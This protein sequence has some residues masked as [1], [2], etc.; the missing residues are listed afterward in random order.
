MG[1]TMMAAVSR[2]VRQPAS[3]ISGE[4]GF[5][6]VEVLVASAILMTG[7]IAVAQMFVT[8]THQNMSARR[9]TT[10]SVLAQQKIEQLRALAWGFDEFGLPVSDYSSNIAVTPPTSSGGVG[11]QASPDFSLFTST[12]GYVDYLDAYGNW[13]G[14]GAA[15]PATAIY[16]RRW[17]I[18]PLP[19]NPNNTIVFQV[20][21]GRIAPDGGPPTDLARQVS[22]KTRKSI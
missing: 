1:Q 16:V 18:D 21:V 7:L 10:T 22:L 4:S 11:L 14:N 9:V 17:S 6:L 13:V 20:L 2:P 8:S 3:R 19:T 15:P 12:P 5:S